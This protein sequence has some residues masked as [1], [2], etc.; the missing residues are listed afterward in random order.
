VSD[1]EIVVSPA[2]IYPGYDYQ[3]L[4]Q[5]VL[6]VPVQVNHI[7][8]QPNSV[9]SLEVGAGTTFTGKKLNIF[10]DD[11]YNSKGSSVFVTASFMYRRMP[12]EGGF[13]WKI[14]FTP[15]FTGRY[16]EGSGGGKC[17]V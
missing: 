8:G 4:Q 6:T 16:V 3:G 7:F 2:I 5:S 9:Y 13:L 1:Y 17:G 15:I 12:K 11:H 14:G 10:D